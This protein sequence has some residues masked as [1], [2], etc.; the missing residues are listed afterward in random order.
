MDGAPSVAPIMSI[1]EEPVADDVDEVCCA[2]GGGDGADV[3]EGLEEGAGGE[4]EE[5]CGGAVVESAEEGDRAGEDGVV[6]GQTHREDGGTEDD[7]DERESQ[8]GG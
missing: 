7:E 6:D 2:Q 3:V 1:D 5:E 8:A 4:V